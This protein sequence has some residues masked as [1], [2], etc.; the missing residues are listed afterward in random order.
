MSTLFY[1][2]ACMCRHTHT[3]SSTHART[4]TH[5]STTQDHKTNPIPG[6]Q[7][8]VDG[9]RVAWGGDKA[10]RTLGHCHLQT[11]KQTIIHSEFVGSIGEGA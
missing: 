9:L 4:H 6:I 10:T 2:H 8:A 11:N 3:S 5:T 7:T 1:I